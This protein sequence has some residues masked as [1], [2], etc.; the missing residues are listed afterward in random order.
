[1]KKVEQKGALGA[2]VQGPVFYSDS[3]IKNLLRRFAYTIYCQRANF[4]STQHPL[5]LR[6]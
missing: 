4:S 2:S 6:I 3:L 1:M 5:E